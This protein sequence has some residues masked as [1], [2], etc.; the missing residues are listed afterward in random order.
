MKGDD[1]ILGQLWVLTD[2]QAI[3][4]GQLRLLD[5]RIGAALAKAD[6]KLDNY[7]RA[8]LV[9]L[10]ARIGKILDASLELPRP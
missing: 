4:A 3:A 6:V 7:S 5:E 9:E 1:G 10:K 8:H 2:A